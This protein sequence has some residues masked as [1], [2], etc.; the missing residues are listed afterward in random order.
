MRFIWGNIDNFKDEKH[1]VLVL[2]QKNV[3]K[4]VYFYTHE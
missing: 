2:A 4:S 1:I 3:L